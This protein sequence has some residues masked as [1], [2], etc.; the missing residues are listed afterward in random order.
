MLDD[1]RDGMSMSRSHHQRAQDEHVQGALKNISGL[2][3]PFQNHRR[4]L[5]SNDYVSIL[6]HSD[7]YGKK[8]YPGIR[9][10]LD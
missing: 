9:I 5:H 2:R 3:W 4:R 8:I 6:L 10:V 1:L 7:D